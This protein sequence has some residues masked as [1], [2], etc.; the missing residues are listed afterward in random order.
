LSLKYLG[1]GN[2]LVSDIDHQL[3]KVTTSSDIYQLELETDYGFYANGFVSS[4]DTANSGFDVQLAQLKNRLFS[5]NSGFALDLGAQFKLGKIS[6]NL[7]ALDLMGKINWKG[8]NANYFKSKGTFEYAGVEIDG[9]D[10]I[11]GTDS[12]SF[13]QKLDSLNDI[14]QFQKSATSFS[15][16][17]PAQFYASVVYELMKSLQF[18]LAFHHGRATAVGVGAQWKPLNFL[19]LGAMYS[20]NDQSRHNLGF[21]LGLTPGPVQLYFATDNLLNAFTLKKSA[22]ASFRAGAALKF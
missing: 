17:L 22:A 8:E 15:T 2:A 12:L 16:E 10:I 9:L 13:S 3:A 5:G 4:I 11:N 7:S 21:Q 20:V 6:V 19:S 18:S 14:F 1:G